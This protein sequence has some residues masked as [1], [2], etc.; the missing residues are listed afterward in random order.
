VVRRPKNISPEFIAPPAGSPAERIVLMEPPPGQ[1]ETFLSRFEVCRELDVSPTTLRDKIRAGL[2][3]PGL[4]FSE[5]GHIRKWP[6]FWVAAYHQ[7][8]ITDARRQLVDRQ[9][10][11][12][13]RA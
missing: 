2:F 8:K 4:P 11:A 1:V 9:Q 5:N 7:S 12:K 3:P 10:R 13:R 6:A